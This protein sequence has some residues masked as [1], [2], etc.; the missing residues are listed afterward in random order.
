MLLSGAGGESGEPCVAMKN[1]LGRTAY[2]RPSH[3]GSGGSDDTSSVHI[4][5]LP[6]AAVSGEQVHVCA[7]SRLGTRLGAAVSEPRE[8]SPFS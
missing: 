3:I 7:G 2:T 6:V 8:R 4:H 1:G 5:R